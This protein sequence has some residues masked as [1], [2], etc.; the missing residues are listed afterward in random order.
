MNL[1]NLSILAYNNSPATDVTKFKTSDDESLECARELAE[2]LY[3]KRQFVDVANFT[4]MC[5]ICYEKFIG[6]K[7]A[8][9][10]AK[11]TGHSNFQET[12]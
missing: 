10:H 6:E 2:E 1:K 11:Q 12:N 9:E 7:D 8:L 4:L 3:K 5:G